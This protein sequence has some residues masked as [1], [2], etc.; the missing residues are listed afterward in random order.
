MSA[1]LPP[2]ITTDDFTRRITCFVG[3]GILPRRTRTGLA[4]LE[5]WWGRR[6]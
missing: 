4:R 3:I 1:I 5:K 6:K 2:K